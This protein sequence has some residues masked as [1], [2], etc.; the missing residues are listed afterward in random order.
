MRS[1]TRAGRLAHLDTWL[2]HE[3]AQLLARGGLVLDVGFGDSPVTVYEMAAALRARYPSLEVCGLEREPSR[4]PMPP[5]PEGVSLRVGAA[6]GPALVVRAM[7][8]L[9]GYPEAAAAALQCQFGEVLVEGGLLLEGSSDTDG[10]VLTC[11]LKRRRGEVLEAEGLLVFSDL[12]RG[13][14]PWQLRDWLPRDLRRGV[15]PG[16]PVHALLT[17]WN[18]F[19]E[20]SGAREPAARFA[21]GLDRVPGL[22]STTWERAHGFVRCM[23]GPTSYTAC[24]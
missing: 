18:D 24:E 23:L 14:S 20:Q 2:L 21:A 22:T 17:A 3:Q 8:V 10:H 12:Q 1:R 7:N 5:W 15:K 19:I 13:F 6:L 9:R 4:V 16:S 11:H